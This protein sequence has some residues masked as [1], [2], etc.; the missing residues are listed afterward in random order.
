MDDKKKLIVLGAM[1][2]A[3]L[4]IGAIQF[5]KAGSSAT[6]APA[7]ASADSSS[8][9]PSVST[10]ASNDAKP[11]AAPQQNDLV[12]G[13]YSQRDPF[14]PLVDAN[15]PAQQQNPVPDHMGSRPIPTGDITGQLPG[16]VPQGTTTPVSPAPPQYGFRLT[17]VIVGRKPA[18]VFIDPQGTQHLVEVGGML[19]GD[20]QLVDLDRNH[21]VVRVKD[22]TK[23][24]MLGGGDSS[25]K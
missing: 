20:T 3:L 19:D 25:A 5:V 11:D 10:V 23:T 2:V 16:A 9:A 24:L 17:G 13:S 8:S 12:S 14:K 21:A 15:P 6:P 1:G 4:G 18:A 7:A 22:Q